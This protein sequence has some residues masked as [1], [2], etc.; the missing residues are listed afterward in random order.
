MTD[1]SATVWHVR[2]PNGRYIGP[3]STHAAALTGARR[4][5]GGGTPVQLPKDA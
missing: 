3:Y 4:V 1:E 2:T 5:P